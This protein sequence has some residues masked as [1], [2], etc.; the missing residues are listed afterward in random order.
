MVP[1]MNFFKRK[2]KILNKIGKKS[3]G[4]PYEFLKRKINILNEIG[5]N[6]V[7]P[8]P[9]EFFLERNQDFEQ[10]WAFLSDVFSEFF[11]NDYF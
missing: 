6:H 5:K 11:Q 8:T 1:P 7:V 10:I 3:Y 2:I 9:Y 4:T